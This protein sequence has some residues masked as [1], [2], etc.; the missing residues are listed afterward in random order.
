M[1]AHPANELIETKTAP[2]PWMGDKIRRD[3]LLARLDAVLSSR[4]T[5]IYAPAGYGKTSL[6]SQW[7]QHHQNSSFRVAWLTLEKDDADP[8]RF[9]HYVWLAVGAQGSGAKRR[10]VALTP[11]DLPARA[12]L[13]AIVNHLGR[14]SRPVVLIFDDVHRA[15]SAAVID[16]LKALIRLAPK[17]C[18]FVIASRDCPR[19]DQSVLAAEGRVREIK[20]E[21]LRFSVSE[22]EALLTRNR[23]FALDREDID[24]IYRRTEGWPIALQLTSL[25]LERSSDRKEWLVSLSGSDSE[26]AHYLSEQV[27]MGLSTEMQEVV[28]HTAVVETLTADLVNALCNRHDGGLLL[29]R[30]VEQ[31]VFL[32]PLA[33]DR[34]IY[35]YHQLIA[36][37]LRERLAAQD[38]GKYRELHGI[39]ARW[40]LKHGNIAQSVNHSIQAEDHAL[41]ATIVRDAGGWRLMQSGL[42]E[43]AVRALDALPAA[44]VAASPHLMLTRI[45]RAIKRGELGDARADYERLLVDADHAETPSDLRTEIEVV[46]DLLAEYE[47][48]PMTLEDLLAK[49][50]LLRT[51]RPGDHLVLGSAS[52]SL[53]AKYYESGRLE[54]AL[55]PVLVA[56][57]HY[58]ARGLIYSDIFTRFHEARIRFAQG[59]LHDATDILAAAQTTIENSFGAHSDLAANCAAFQSELL[60]EQDHLQDSLE[61]L[62]WSL[63]HMEQFDGWVDVYAAAYS[64]AAR[65]AAASGQPESAQEYLARG[66]RL[67][68]RRGLR[69]LELLVQLCELHLLLNQMPTPPE[70]EQIA[71]SLN[72]DEL[73]NTMATESPE[74]RRVAVS[75]ALCRAKLNLISRRYDSALTELAQIKQWASQHGGGRLLIDVHL[76]MASG[77]HQSGMFK[78]AQSRFNEAVNVAM[79]QGFVRPFLDAQRFI[80]ALVREALGETRRPDRYRD[81]FLK[82]LARKFANQPLTQGTTGLT[83]AELSVLTY[84]CSGY[85][86]KEI[87]RLIGM[88]S[89]TVKYRLKSVFRKLG[90]AK[91]REAVNVARE[92]SLVSERG[93]AVYEEAG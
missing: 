75:A 12:M 59:R 8:T 24:R 73:A 46:G 51:L 9:M 44:T 90:V 43:V 19:L 50:A 34:R 63:P 1:M 74:F 58:Q 29:E 10:D 16:A 77:L 48:R 13:S 81:R 18:H 54:R 69:Q 62:E 88:S 83:S 61:L 7:R 41:L 28:L 92:R 38:M 76:L 40:F 85:S 56:R 64:T 3:G 65:A 82:D 4:L 80:E 72:L 91:R 60:Y 6:L 55:E 86:N 87:A 84:L 27:L 53:G 49:E 5:L 23:T 37:Y 79:A 17:N 32:T 70:S 36:E 2:P 22:A 93:V 39:A 45:C 25:S 20:A 30:L 57:E 26:L 21:D 66:R 11:P 52:E 47:N 14:I 78:Q 15:D 68:N 67:A 33:E 35:R 42:Q 71:K 31:S 89:D